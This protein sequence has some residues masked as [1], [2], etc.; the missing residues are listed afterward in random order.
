[1]IPQGGEPIW[2]DDFPEP[3]RYER[4]VMRDADLRADIEAEFAAQRGEKHGAWAAWDGARKRDERS[5]R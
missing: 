1:M 2:L 5:G 3:S 4:Q